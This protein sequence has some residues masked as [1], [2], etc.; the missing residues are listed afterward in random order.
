MSESAADLAFVRELFSGMGSV[1]T[2][3]MF[4]GAGLYAGDVMFGL[5]DDGRVFLKTDPT[6]ATDLAA[7]GAV[8]WI[9]TR[10]QTPPQKSS[11]LSL[12][13]SALD[14]PDEACD[15]GRR[16]LAAAQA[17]KAAPPKRSRKG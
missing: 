15:W 13:E 3:R 9:Y 7:A 1:T 17:K 2:R 6:L 4:G 12:P 14:D 11:Y 10:A 16:A 8:P 5:I